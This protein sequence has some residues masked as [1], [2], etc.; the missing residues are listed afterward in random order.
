MVIERVKVYQLEFPLLAPYRLSSGDLVLFDPIVVEVRDADGREGWGEALIVPGYTPESV[1]DA[2]KVCCELGARV[3]GMGLEAARRAALE[4][5]HVSAGAVSALLAALDMV[6][7]HPLLSVDQDT[8]VPLLAPC[9][10]HEPPE[11]D[12]EVD[13]LIANGFHTLKVKVGYRWQDD[14]ERV[15][16]IQRAVNARATLRLDANRGFS[17]ADGK[18]FASRLDPRGIELFE[19]PCGADDWAANAAVA[20]V[21]TVSV[22]LDESIYGLEDIERAAGVPGVGHIKLKLKKIGSVDM[23]ASALQRIRALGLTPVLGDGVSIEIGCWMEAGVATRTISNAGEMNG[24]LKARERLF[25]NPLGFEA[26]GIVLRR[27]YWPEIDRK[28]LAAHTR[29]VREFGARPIPV[30]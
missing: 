14:L 5:L 9:Q 25:A 29:V 8:R 24:F 18:A 23:L 16:L 27:G 30:G 13:R 22:M 12:A 28:A 6:T 26:G 10:A 20:A 4:R 1:D 3:T 19:Q 17:E 2:W 7:R 21:S 15:E 11:I